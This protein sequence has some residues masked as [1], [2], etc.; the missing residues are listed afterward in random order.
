MRAEVDE[1]CALGQRVTD[2]ISCHAGKKYLAAMTG[3]HQA[4]YPVNRRAE[5]IGITLVGA[6]CVQAHAHGQT[7][8]GRKVFL[9]NGAL[10]VERGCKRI[11]RGMER[12]AKG[13]ANGLEHATVVPLDCGAHEYIM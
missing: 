4:C 8:D 3:G 2:K 9:V 6:T 12:G 1:R 13:V 5:I 11:W 7:R 10:R